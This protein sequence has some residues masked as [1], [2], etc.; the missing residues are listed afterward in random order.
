MGNFYKAVY[1]TQEEIPE[2]IFASMRYGFII[3]YGGDIITGWC[4]NFSA[5]TYS[6][7]GYTENTVGV[8][9]N[10]VILNIEDTFYMHSTISVLGSQI[11]FFPKED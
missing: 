7:S 2:D 3:T 9:L 11:I 4:V 6:S 5:K 8:K 10:N 1:K